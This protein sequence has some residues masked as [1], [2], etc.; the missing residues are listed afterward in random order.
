MTALNVSSRSPRYDLSYVSSTRSVAGYFLC[1]DHCAVQLM[2]P[3]SPTKRQRTVSLLNGPSRPE[4]VAARPAKAARR[5]QMM[6]AYISCML[7]ERGWRHVDHSVVGFIAL[8]SRV[9]GPLWGGRKSACDP[10]VWI[11]SERRLSTHR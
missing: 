3:I 8:L 10:I 1:N 5:V 4:R 2:V 11:R 9:R 6:L 7:G